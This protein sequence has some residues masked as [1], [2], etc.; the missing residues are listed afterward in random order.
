MDNV[1][2]IRETLN[3]RIDLVERQNK[4]CG[5]NEECNKETRN[6]MVELHLYW[7]E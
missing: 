6:E 7:I 5:Y 3:E 2:D 1:R 4:Q